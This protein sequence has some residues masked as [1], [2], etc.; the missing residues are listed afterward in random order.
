MNIIINEV[1]HKLVKVEETDNYVEYA[2][3]RADSLLGSITKTGAE[4]YYTGRDTDGN[5]KASAAT[6]RDTLEAMIL[7]IFYIS[8]FKGDRHIITLGA[9]IEGKEVKVEYTKGD[10]VK[11]SKRVVRYSAA[12]GDLYIVLDNQKYFYCEFN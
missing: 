12:A 4:I 7:N 2:I 3:Y 8:A 1:S 6:L 11:H 5:I 10:I 9:W